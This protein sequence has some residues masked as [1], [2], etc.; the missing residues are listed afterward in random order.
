MTALR[1]LMV[2]VFVL[3]LVW[4]AGQVRAADRPAG[5]DLRA[6]ISVGRVRVKAGEEVRI[7][8]RIVNRGDRKAGPGRA[9]VQADGKRIHIEPRPSLE[10]GQSYR[11]SFPWTVEGRGEVKLSLT[12]LKT[13]QPVARARLLVGGRLKNGPDLN[14][15]WARLPERGCLG[16]GPWLAQVVVR[17]TGGLDSAAGQVEFFINGR[18]T[19][20]AEIAPLKPNGQVW[21]TFKWDRARRGTNTLSAV[22]DDKAGQNDLK[23]SDNRVVGD[24]NLV[25]CRPDLVMVGLAVLGPVE[26]DRQPLRAKAMVINR[27]GRPVAEAKVV[28]FI[29]GRE[30]H[31]LRLTNLKPGQRRPVAVE[32]MPKAGG[33]FRLAAEIIGRGGAV[34]ADPAD[35]RQEIKFVAQVPRPDLRVRPVKTDPT[36]CL[37]DQPLRLTAAVA[38][39]GRLRAPPC[40]LVLFDGPR[41]LAATKIASLGPGESVWVKLSWRPDK[42]GRYRL[43]LVA[44]PDK[45]INDPRR[46]NNRQG[47]GLLIRNCPP[48][49]K[50]D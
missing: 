45:L 48:P 42:P 16:G 31:T 50:S 9:V 44:D 10:P 29:D 3:S 15:K 8:V 33:T 12:F 32:W 4:A 24:F 17:N 6:D 20:A 39:V 35:N 7:Q 30:I 46:I 19:A 25:E 18:P 13:K 1:R 2:V 47:F 49:T 28:F 14:I 34:E 37:S 43:I 21:L 22:I 41:R 27:G 40:D 5:A 38:N 36:P 11:Y 23:P 26:V